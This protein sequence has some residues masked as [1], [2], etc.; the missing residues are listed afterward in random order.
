LVS[1]AN[2]LMVHSIS[3]SDCQYILI[4]HRI[5]LDPG[6]RYVMTSC[7]LDLTSFTITLWA[8]S[9]SLF[10]NQWRV[11]PLKPWAT[12]FFRRMLWN[13]RIAI[14]TTKLPPLNVLFSFFLTSSSIKLFHFIQN[15]KYVNNIFKIIILNIWQKCYLYVIF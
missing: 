9:S 7:Q 1:L 11:H 8:W 6:K 2:L 3:L 13:V 15:H 4:W 10:F 5:N 14:F 12:S